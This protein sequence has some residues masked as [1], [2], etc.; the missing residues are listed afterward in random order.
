[1]LALLFACSEATKVAD[2][3]SP[4]EMPDRSGCTLSET[5][6]HEADGVVD[7][8]TVSAY[9]AGDHMVSQ[10]LHYVDVYDLALTAEWDGDCLVAYGYVLDYAG[11][12]SQ[13]ATVSWTQTCDAHDLPVQ[14]DGTVN[15][16]PYTQVYTTTY[17]GD[18]PVE[19]VMELADTQDARW[20]WTYAWDGDLLV[21]ETETFQ[22]E[23]AWEQAWAYDDD[24]NVVEETYTETDAPDDD[25]T[26][27]W[28]WDEHGRVATT[29]YAD[30]DGSAWEVAYTWYDA[31]YHVLAQATDDGADGTVDTEYT[32]D[33]S[34]AWPWTC[35]TTGDGNY[36]DALD[37]A[38]D[39]RAT[40]SWSCD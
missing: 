25:Y 23:L 12:D 29:A 21:G 3:P 31:I 20:V 13:D 33:C 34:D 14:R 38:V 17:D 9:G 30:G 11:S 39:Y 1:M 10:D 22:D 26:Q 4:Y 32:S 28:T 6:D 24:G 40:A 19:V 37:G 5:T 7:L 2:P 15:G 18:N 35:E 27:R 8:E 16:D 36:P